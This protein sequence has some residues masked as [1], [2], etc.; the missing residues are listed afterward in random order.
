MR[1]EYY[2]LREDICNERVR[3]AV[4]SAVKPLE[5]LAYS[6]SVYLKPVRRECKECMYFPCR[7][8]CAAKGR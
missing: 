4:E 3:K 1:I 8:K 7:E 5:S 6:V 2:G